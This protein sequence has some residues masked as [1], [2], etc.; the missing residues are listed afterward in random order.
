MRAIPLFAPWT[1]PEGF[2]P[3]SDVMP[4][5]GLTNT[6]RGQLSAA[7][8]PALPG[9]FW[10]GDAVCTTNPA[11][12]R[13]VSLGLRQ[14]S[15]LLTVLAE[16]GSDYPASAFAFDA[17]CQENIRPWFEDHVLWDATLLRRFRGQ[18]LDLNAKIPSDVVCA[19]GTEVDPAMMPG[20]GPYMGMLA[21]PSVLD[22]FQGRARQVLQS[23][24]RPALAEGP[25]RDELV[26]LMAATSSRR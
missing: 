24:W 4:G 25:G 5:G 3:I 22:P 7:G 10:V 19:I 17:W 15:T 23:G 18:D 11:A 13:G 1:D 2:E 8:S 6:Y 14:A 20:V 21:L 9:V 16:H 12:G 26:E